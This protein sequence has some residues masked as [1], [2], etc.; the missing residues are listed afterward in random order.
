MHWTEE[1]SKL[2]PHME[3]H[4]NLS[5]RIVHCRYLLKK[6]LRRFLERYL[7]SGCA[8][9]KIWFAPIVQA[10]QWAIKRAT[11]NTKIM[12]IAIPTQVIQRIP[13]KMML[14]IMAALATEK[15]LTGIRIPEVFGSV[16]F[17]FAS[18]GHSATPRIFF[19]SVPVA[20]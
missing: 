1:N 12:N 3:C 7:M 17:K 15:V 4:L 5:V 20:F 9:H 2:K 14:G 13:R 8:P 16:V 6:M 11:P 19:T 10:T 18:A